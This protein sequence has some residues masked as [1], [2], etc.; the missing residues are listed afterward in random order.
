VW[1]I[2]YSIGIEDVGFV[3]ANHKE[4]LQKREPQREFAKKIHRENARI[5]LMVKIYEEDLR[6]YGR[7]EKRPN[8]FEK[9]RFG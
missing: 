8:S 6:E 5:R 9:G 2:N 4:T 3:S 1:V 7:K